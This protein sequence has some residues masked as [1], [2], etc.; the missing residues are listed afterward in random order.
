M[1]KQPNPV[2]IPDDTRSIHKIGDFI[3]SYEPYQNAY[4]KALV[5]RVGRVLVTSS[6]W[7]DA[8]AVFD[9]GRLEYGE[10]VEEIFANIA[11][12]FSFDPA[13]AETKL[14]KRHIP[15]VR[16]AF[17]SMNW[18][19]VYP[20]TVSNDQ[21]RQAFISY[22]EMTSLIAYIVDTLYTAMSLDVFLTKKYMLCREALNGG[23]YTVVTAPISGTNANPEDAV[24]KYREYTNNLT[25]LKTTYNRAH[26][27]NHTPIDKQVIIVPNKAEAVIGVKVLAAAFNLSEVDYISRRIAVDSFE[28]DADDEERLA[29]LFENDDTYVP[30]T[31]PEKLALQ[32][33]NAVKL[34]TDW[35]MCFIN[36]E[37]FTENYNGLGL[38][39]QY[40][41]HVWRTFS[42]SPF[43]N[44]VLFTEQASEITSVTVSP[45]TAN[46]AQGTFIQMNA[47]V[48][49]TGLF[50]KTVTWSITSDTEL[51]S[52]TN[53]D[54]GTGVLRIAA[55]EVA[56]TGITVTATAVDGQTGTATIT[57]VASA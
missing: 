39:W 51:A 24:E 5:N 44:A 2:R 27:R 34:D 19:K 4:I 7:E 53:I 46:V 18:Q 20:V 29:L 15:D 50:D 11:K 25:F 56:D 3:M 9:K 47:V 41:Y 37:Q 35:F 49:G 8:W 12:P 57:V 54:G 45:T 55:D 30:F 23:I 48:A 14:Y 6:L 21:L 28:F 22:G 31:G 52:G 38:Y 43:A 40:F 17:H 36:F 13:E 33:I 42:A 1:P 32:K 26:V 10:T 16:A